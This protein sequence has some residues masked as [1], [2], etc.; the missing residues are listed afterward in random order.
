MSRA[1]SA[2]ISSEIDFREL[3]ARYSRADFREFK[4]WARGTAQ[5]SRRGGSLVRSVFVGSVVVST[6]IS[7][8]LSALVI[9][10]TMAT[11]SPLWAT[12][13]GGPVIAAFIYLASVRLIDIWRRDVRLRVRW[14]R[15]MNLERF[16]L[17]NT[18]VY[19][20]EISSPS[21]PGSIFT[22]GT[23]RRAFDVVTT[24]VGRYVEIGNYSFSGA[25]GLNR[26]LNHCGYI[27]TLVDRRLPHLYLKS[28]K[29]RRFGAAFMRS[30]EFSLEGDFGKYFR[31]YTPLGYERDALYIFTPD[32][33]AVLIDEASDF[34][35]EFVD[36]QVFFYSPRRFAMRDPRTY[37]RVVA[38]VDAVVGKALRQTRAYSDERTTG[39][40]VAARG[41]RLGRG[42]TLAM[43][44]GV[45]ILVAQITRAIIMLWNAAH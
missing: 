27:R 6:F 43:V 30:Q 37:R 32:L 33:M 19:T 16:T 45:M 23:A 39:N 38:V 20:P 13:V 36:T 21:Y 34:D 31:L 25:S 9:F 15:W 4:K 26:S 10:S 12:L 44:V 3:H 8:A 42:V 18:M 24:S 11:T 29:S 40:F 1:T 2:S 7:I 28:R 35:V 14:R 22:I 41:A 17:A 5:G